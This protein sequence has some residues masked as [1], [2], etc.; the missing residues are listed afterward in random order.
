MQS[1]SRLVKLFR[2]GVDPAFDELVHRY[3]GALVAYAGAIAGRDRAEDVVQDSLVK[4]HRSLSGEQAIEP[5]PWL[6]KVVRNTALNDIRDNRKHSHDGLGETA[7]Q[8]YEQP[9][10]VAERREELAAVVAAVSAL[11]A[12]Q[13]R[14]LIGHELGGF[15]YDEIAAELD[16][17][18]GATKQLIY[19]ARLSLRNGFGA[20]IPFPLIAWLASDATSMFAA[21]AAGGVA[22]GAAATG[23]LGASGGAAVGT[24][25]TGGFFAGLAGAGTTKLAVVA[26]VAGGSIAGGV[27]AERHHNSSSKDA[28]PTVVTQISG[29]SAGS[30]TGGP[31]TPASIVSS[32]GGVGSSGSNSS[33]SGSHSK[34]DGG[35]P[36]GGDR[37]SSG[38]GD[39]S[40]SDD[41]SGSE[42]GHSGSGSGH[43]GH[44]EPRPDG[45]QPDDSG[46]GSGGDQP[47]PSSP[48][49]DDAPR[50]SQPPGD[51]SSGS[52]S[53]DSGS[54]DTGSSGSGSG[55]DGDDVFP[56]A[57]PAPKPES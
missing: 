37:P 17:S 32:I 3:R 26:I 40:G 25:G 35:N 14:A 9:H 19:R 52:G 4:A 42:D 8:A 6:Y 36:S 11:P 15:S 31:Q 27:A 13:R 18:T 30:S 21:G 45:D 10:E 28:T 22:T 46:P 51:G 12:S 23:A 7:T 16:V 56:E 20:L 55:D 57:A 48:S 53:S 29:D 1:D 47:D 33:G 44:R 50:P 39:D 54:D 2:R 5:K 41:H 43:D 38:S 24:A 34:H 49:D